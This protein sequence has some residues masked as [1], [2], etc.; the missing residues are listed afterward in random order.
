[1]RIG[2]AVVLG[3]FAL[4]LAASAQEPESA[5]DR[6]FRAFWDA[7]HSTAAANRID[8]ILK[9]GVPFDEALMRVRHGR[10]YEAGVPK[11]LQFGRHRTF[12]GLD[13]EYAF[14][15]PKNYEPSRP[16]Q[17]RF[18][19]HGGIAR[20]RPPLVDRMRTDALPGVVEE[21]SVFPMGWVR[22]LWW[23]ATHTTSMK[24]ACI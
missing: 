6:A 13:H 21:I 12:D 24:T 16:Y 8:A 4:T 7:P 15:V 5:I 10:A 1:V 23:S 9:T 20:A 2:F 22:S 18:Q 17:V 3:S 19:L 11:G 14:I